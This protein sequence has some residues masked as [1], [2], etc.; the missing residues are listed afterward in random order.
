VQ[1]DPDL[2]PKLRAN[3][4][5]TSVDMLSPKE[6]T[7]QLLAAKPRA[8]QVH[9]HSIIGLVSRSRLGLEGLL[10]GFGVPEVGDGV[11][12]YTSAHLDNVDSEIT[13]PAEHMHVHHHPLAVREVRRILLEHA[14]SHEII[15]LVSSPEPASHAQENAAPVRP[16][17]NQPQH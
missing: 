6:E 14:K 7:L 16:Q 2:P 9:F 1:E 11:V 4:I 10:T 3:G 12:P 13:V 5:P 15:K 17:A 8:E